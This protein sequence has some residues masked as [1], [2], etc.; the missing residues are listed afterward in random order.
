MSYVKID[1]NLYYGIHPSVVYPDLKINHFVD[2]TEEGECSELDSKESTFKRFEIKDKREP[3]L[4]LLKDIINYIEL[5]PKED[6]VYICCKGGHGRSGLVASALYGK[7]NNL[8]G[9][10]ALKYVN[11]E[12]HKQRDLTKI[13]VKFIKLGSPQTI[14][15]KNIVKKYLDEKLNTECIK[16]EINLHYNKLMFYEEKDLYYFFSNF[17]THKNPLVINDEKWTNTEQYFQ[18]MKFRGKKATKRMIEYSNIIKNADTPMKVKLLGTQKKN[19]GY[20][21][22]WKINKKT[23]PRLLNEIVDQYKDINIRDNWNTVSVYVM[24]DAVCNKFNQYDFLKKE[25]LKIPDNTYIIEHTT[26]DKI[27]GDGGDGGDGTKGKNQLGKILTALIHI[28]KYR[29]CSNMSLELKNQIR[30]DLT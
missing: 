8:S 12:W 14:N 21:K 23:D 18:A 11:D 20:G 16:Q 7:R 13:R 26:R 22:S 17:Y 24:I 6:G 10:D 27:W 9:D 25:I 4:Y 30:L 29:N 19:M 3:T 28:I 1:N 5:L 2:L 15:Q